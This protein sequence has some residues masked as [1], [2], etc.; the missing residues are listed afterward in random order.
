M[1]TASQFA[2]AE[3][4]CILGAAEYVLMAYIHKF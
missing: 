4:Q 2:I 1:L 3:K